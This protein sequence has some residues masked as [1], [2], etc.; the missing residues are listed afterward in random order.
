MSLR[1]AAT[2]TEAKLEANRR[3]ARGSRGPRTEA[4]KQKARLNRLKHG[5]WAG[6]GC[7]A[8]EA[9]RA[10]GEDPEEYQALLG[11]LRQAEGPCEDPL[12]RQQVED[13]ARLYWRRKRLERTLAVLASRRLQEAEEEAGE[14]LSEAERA[15][16]GRE[17]ALLV[18]LTPE[19]MELER[20]LEAVER[21]ID[22]KTRLLLRLREEA[23][24][25]G[26]RDKV[27][28]SAT[29]TKPAPVAKSEARRSEP[30]E[31]LPL[32][33]TIRS[34]IRVLEEALG[35]DR[36]GIMENEIRSQNVLENTE[37]FSDVGA[38]LS[39]EEGRNGPRRPQED[40]SRSPA[41][42]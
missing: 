39:G 4:G 1:R 28:R 11:R 34:Y 10:L 38:Q 17:E 29:G 19:G 3:N 14:E 32:T 30:D 23:E 35:M 15:V 25:R 7:Y 9:L 13:L 24:R 27:A 41:E 36:S 40:G 26:R 37:G 31:D 12:W 21:A 6:A 42:Q 22:R 8:P 33:P 5:A 18:T 16:V 2:L 20:H